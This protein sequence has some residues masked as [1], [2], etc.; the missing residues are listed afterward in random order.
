M[1]EKEAL[2]KF[3]NMAY[4]LALKFS[5]V[6][7]FEDMY[8]V[9]KI[10]IIDAVRS[11]DIKRGAKLSTH[12]FNMIISHLRK[13]NA[14]DT[15]II[16]YPPHIVDRNISVFNLSEVFDFSS[17]HE[18]FNSVELNYIIDNAMSKLTEKQKRI[19]YMRYILGHSV[20]EIAK[21]MNCSHQNISALCNKAK[22]ILKSNIDI[23]Y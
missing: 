13:F 6:H 20:P 14:K 8:Q 11:F 7:D 12:V 22:N 16:Y 10:G 1:C 21:R 19:V 23:N 3:D 18:L 15:G 9:A 5:Y 17:D 2:I 4:K